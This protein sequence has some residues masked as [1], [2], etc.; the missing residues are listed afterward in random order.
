MT[1]GTHDFVLV[2]ISTTKLVSVPGVEVRIEVEDSDRSVD[3]E[4][5]PE[6]GQDDRVVASE[7]QDTGVLFAVL[8]QV[9]SVTLCVDDRSVDESRVGC[10]H[11]VNG[12]GGVVGRDRD[13]IA[14]DLVSAVQAASALTSSRLDSRTTLVPHGIRKERAGPP[15]R[16]PLRIA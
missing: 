16:D 9:R 12:Q 15:R 1:Y 10:L 7:R 5:S 3:I 4:K 13:V 2:G 11:L 6:D 8:C 14:V